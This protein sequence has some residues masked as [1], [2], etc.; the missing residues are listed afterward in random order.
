MRVLVTGGA[1]FIGSH[2]CDAFVARGNEVCVID[3]LSR[4]QIGR[5]PEGTEVCKAS[6]L[7][8]PA[9]TALVAEFRPELICHLAAQVDVRVSVEFPSKDAEANVIGMI[10]VLDAA[11]VV[12]ARVIFSSTG[13]AIYGE[14]A[15][16]PSPE[17]TLPEPS[18]PYGVGK[19]CAEQYI[20][21]YNRMFGTAHAILRFANV[22][23]P[24]QGGAGEAG[25]VSI[26]CGNG[27]H[28]KP[29]T[30]YGDGQQTR[31]YVYVGD[32]VAAF[33]AA[34]DFGQ[35]GIWNIGS[36]TEVSVLDLAG[37]VA[38]LTGRRSEL[39]FAPARAGE[40]LRSAL[41]WERAGRDLGWRP[42]TSLA[43]GLQAVVGWFA[44]GAPDR[45]SR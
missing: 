12:G 22:Y 20:G 23:G 30:I 32:C 44:A 38:G 35:A 45:T 1:G 15:R 3:N 40:L 31:D 41:A 14:G 26:F 10:N 5:V 28:G 24:R 18:S 17:E 13:G 34:A 37:L 16:I 21:L 11:R 43:D 8:A 27:I 42:A 33:L 25:V 7:D 19:Y 9:L 39:V 2:V 6:I 29:I 4:G 36:G